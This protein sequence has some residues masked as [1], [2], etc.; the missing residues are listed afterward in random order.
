MSYSFSRR[1]T[2]MSTKHTPGPWKI[3]NELNRSVDSLKQI[4]YWTV[5]IDDARGLAI[6]ETFARWAPQDQIEANARLIA[7]APELLS[8]VKYCRGIQKAFPDSFK[9]TP[10]FGAEMDAL[11]AKAE[12][13][14]ESNEE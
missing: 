10:E 2:S 3:R 13:R 1:R 6:V 11:I 5:G 12:G 9:A 14:G 7:A 4:P 8:M